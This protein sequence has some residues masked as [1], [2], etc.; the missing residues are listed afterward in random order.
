MEQNNVIDVEFYIKFIND[1]SN[2]TGESI[3]DVDD[4]Y[5]PFYNFIK[6]MVVNG[7][8]YKKEKLVNEMI[9]MEKCFPNETHIIYEWVKDVRAF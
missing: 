8:D 2:Y 1:V 9:K 6:L 7:F 3:R 4:V 5:R